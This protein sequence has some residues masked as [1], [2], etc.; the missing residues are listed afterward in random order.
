MADQA[1]HVQV[2]IRDQ[3]A[4]VVVHASVL[5]AHS[6]ELDAVA[7]LVGVVFLAHSR[8]TWST[9]PQEQKSYRVEIVVVPLLRISVSP[10]RILLSLGFLQLAPFRAVGL[11]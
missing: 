6:E 9:P 4:Q 11:F 3:V 1:Q 7:A 10:L 8:W 5:E 2:Y